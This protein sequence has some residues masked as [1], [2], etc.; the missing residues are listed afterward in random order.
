M[1][2]FP[3]MLEPTR[4]MLIGAAMAGVVCKGY[5]WYGGGRVYSNGN[6]GAECKE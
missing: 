2:E 3:A 4:T 6:V 1:M 5:G